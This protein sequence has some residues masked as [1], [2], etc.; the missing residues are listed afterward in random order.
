MEETWTGS[1]IVPNA[2]KASLN[3]VPTNEDASINNNGVY[4]LDKKCTGRDAIDA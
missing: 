2:Y 4:S 1:C 3:P